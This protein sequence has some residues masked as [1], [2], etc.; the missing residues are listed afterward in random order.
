MKLSVRRIAVGFGWW[1]VFWAG[2]IFIVS[3][4]SSFQISNQ[5]LQAKDA[6][7]RQEVL[8]V[9]SRKVADKYAMPIFFGSLLLVTVGTLLEI[10][11]GIK[12]K[13]NS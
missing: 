8:R 5:V 12:N 3:T 13:G 2:L 6:Q 11:P 1:L 10:L 4:V 7:E 9:Y